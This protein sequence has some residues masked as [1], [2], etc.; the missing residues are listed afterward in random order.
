MNLWVLFTISAALFQTVRFVLQKLLSSADR[1]LSVAGATF[2]RFVYS[3]PIVWGIVAV[4]LYLYG[5][6]L[7]RFSSWFAVY[8][9]L[10]GLAQIF[11]TVLVLQLFK[12]RNFAV[13]I[14]L[15]KTEAI[16]AA[17]VG[18]LILSE[19]VSLLGFVAILL[20][21][22]GVILLT[23]NPISGGV[24]EAGL[25]RKSAAYGLGAGALF[26]LSAVMYRGATLELDQELLLIR[27]GLTLT[28][29]ITWQTLIM[30]A[31]LL[32]FDPHEVK[33][34]W[35]AR[36]RALWVGLTSVCGSFCWFAAFAL[37]TAAYVK[38]LGQVELLFGFLASVLF[39]REKI[40]IYEGLGMTIL[41]GSILLLLLVI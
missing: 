41:L 28:A 38:A 40:T 3:F 2:S 30:A 18:I 35:D 29:V 5:F 17:F 19:G 9:I 22:V 31:W 10:G 32:Y 37:Q 25:S 26:A 36:R 39:F 23:K 33:A 16:L 12:L 8:V 1:A 34:V 6:E 7:P 15:K 13:G 21:S 27:A 20:G 4:F 14:T 11:A 24:F